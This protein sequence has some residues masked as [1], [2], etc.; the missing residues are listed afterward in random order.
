MLGTVRLKRQPPFL[1]RQEPRKIFSAVAYATDAV[2][3]PADLQIYRFTDLQIYRLL[4]TLVLVFRWS[5][6]RIPAYAG[7]TASNIPDTSVRRW[8]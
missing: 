5:P 2:E 3:K 7:M 8:E 1:R 4:R 6:L